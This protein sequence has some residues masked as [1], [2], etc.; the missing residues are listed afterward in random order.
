[1]KNKKTLIL[2]AVLSL[3]PAA[4]L[5]AVWGQL[6]ETVVTT[7]GFDGAVNGTGSKAALWAMVLLGPL[8]CAMMAFL[9]KI[10]PKR[11]SYQKFQKHYDGFC[12]AFQLFFA[13]VNAASIWENLH[14]GTI[15]I[16][17]VVTILMGFLFLFLGNV[18][19]TFKHNY[20]VGIK[21]PWTLADPQVWDRA[22][23]LGGVLFFWGGLVTVLLALFLPE[24]VFF[25]LFMAMVLAI[26]L[27]PCVMSYVWYRKL[28]PEG[29]G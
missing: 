16:G 5:L 23:R 20:F 25:W 15:S 6:P 3:L 10:D 17:R 29:R 26:A 9:P 12:V 19:P 18:M 1:M 4:L 28:H 2:C 8:L 11:G 24:T 13:A 14:P 7:W 22:N 27:A 21:T